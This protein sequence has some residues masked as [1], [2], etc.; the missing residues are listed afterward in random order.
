MQWW[1]RECCHQDIRRREGAGRKGHTICSMV[2]GI[3][4]PKDEVVR[5][6]ELEYNLEQVHR[7][8]PEGLGSNLDYGGV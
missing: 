5:F 2:G 4:L 7:R 1:S 6:L 3:A 8:G